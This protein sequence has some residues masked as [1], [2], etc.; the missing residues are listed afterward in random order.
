MW[1]FFGYP[2]TMGYSWTLSEG[3]GVVVVVPGT[4]KID[5]GSCRGTKKIGFGRAA[6]ENFEVSSFKRRFGE[7]WERKREREGQNFRAPAARG[8]IRCFSIL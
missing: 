7:L 8:A 5:V 2:G 6:A 4:K 3:G 1:S